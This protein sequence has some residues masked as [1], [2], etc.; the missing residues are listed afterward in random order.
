MTGIILSESYTMSRQLLSCYSGNSLCS[1]LLSL[2]LFFD[3][4]SIARL[5]VRGSILVQLLACIVN[6]PGGV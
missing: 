6:D 1:S 3:Q 2:V 5:K 4:V